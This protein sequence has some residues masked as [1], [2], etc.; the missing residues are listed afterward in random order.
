MGHG[1]STVGGISGNLTLAVD[2]ANPLV[3][4]GGRLFMNPF[5]AIDMGGAPNLVEIFGTR[6]LG[7]VLADGAVINGVIVDSSL[8][9][10]TLVGNHWNPNFEFVS[11]DHE[12]WGP[13]PT[14]NTHSLSRGHT[15]R[16]SL[17]T[18]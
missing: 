7:N 11:W 14:R 2:Q 6:R 17:S 12:Q 1:T 18:T 9:P 10:G 5:S 3:D 16:R 15:R 13:T 8:T 4:N